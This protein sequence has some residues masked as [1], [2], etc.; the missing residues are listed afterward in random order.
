VNMLGNPLQ[1][2]RQYDTGDS[3]TRQVL[4]LE[5]SYSLGVRFR[6]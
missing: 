5:R 3:Y 4:Y 1:R 2:Y 6:F